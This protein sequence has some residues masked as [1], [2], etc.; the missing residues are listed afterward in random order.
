[1]KIT[2]LKLEENVVSVCSCFETRT[3]SL[4]TWTLDY[5]SKEQLLLVKKQ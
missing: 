2:S 4:C 1:M 5:T 3:A